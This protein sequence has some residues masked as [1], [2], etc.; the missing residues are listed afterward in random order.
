MGLWRCTDKVESAAASRD[1]VASA[2]GGDATALALLLE[3]LLDPAYRLAFSMLKEREAA[4]D[5]VQEA[6]LKALQNVRKL[7][8]DTVT[9]RPWFFTIVANQCRSTRRS[10]WWAVV[11]LGDLAPSKSPENTLTEE[12]IDLA[13]AMA[14]IPADQR[15]ALAL[16]YYLDLPMEEVAGVIGISLAAAKSR[17]RRALTTLAPALT[18]GDQEK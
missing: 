10:R 18:A 4:E 3:P 6:A 5:A 13:R 14:Q 12:R 8:S 16:R 1:L 15:L 2:R 11:R 7:R 17:V 9:L